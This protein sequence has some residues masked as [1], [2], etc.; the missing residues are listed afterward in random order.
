MASGARLDHGARPPGRDRVTA[1]FK[2]SWTGSRE[3]V[4]TALAVLGETTEGWIFA[5]SGDDA[6][7]LLEAY[8]ESGAALPRLAEQARQSCGGLTLRDTGEVPPADWVA[9]VQRGLG[10]VAA[11]RFTVHGSH[12]RAAMRGKA[13]AI[14]IDAGLAFGTAHHATTR[15][16]LLALDRFA[17][18]VGGQPVRVL[19]LGT[20]SGVLAIAAA[21]VMPRA[22]ILATDIDPV[23]IRVARG[24]AQRNRVGG[25][26]AFAVATG[27]ASPET[28]RAAP[29]DLVLANI[30]AGPLVELARDAVNY[31][32]ECCTVVLSG[33]LDSQ[34]REVGAAFQARGFFRRHSHASDGWTT[35]TLAA[36]P[37]A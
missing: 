1:V 28:A 14:E 23:A 7:W 20:G 6:D 16:C 4:E 11:G 31:A 36:R 12:D 3:A 26:I 9:I 29:F 35:L 18:R 24:N 13:H 37:R 8:G 21:R 27:F 15:G 2:A 19:D 32:A 10:P 17:K 33:L 5:A 34:A 22:A 25:R 30:L